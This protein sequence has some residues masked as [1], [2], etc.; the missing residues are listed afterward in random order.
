MLQQSLGRLIEQVAK[1]RGMNKKVII[2]ALEAA[3]LMAAKKKYGLTKEIEAHFNEEIDDIELFQFKTV[4]GKIQDE[5]MEI[6]LKEAKKLDPE[7]TVGD[8]I[9]VKLDAKKFGRIDAQTVKQVITQKVLEA[10]KDLVYKEYFHRKGEIISGIVRRYERGNVMVDLGKTEA[11]IPPREQIPGENFRSGDRVQA[12]ILDVQD[13]T[14]R[15]AQVVLSR[16]TPLYLIK[17]FELEVPEVSE[18]I[19]IIKGAAR[20]P[21]FRSKISVYSKD[22]DVDAVG[23]CVGV[24]GTRV[25]NVVQEL[26]GEKIDIVPWSDNDMQFVVNALAPAEIS[27]VIIDEVNHSM[28]VIV[29]DDQLSLAIG[30]KGQNVRLAMQLAGWKLDIITESKILER[31]TRAKKSLTAIPR[32]NETLAMGLYQNGYDTFE[33]VAKAEVKDLLQVPGIGD[34][35]KA[36]SLKQEAQVLMDQGLTTD[37]LVNP[38]R[39][40][41]Q[42]S[43]SAETQKEEVK[44]EIKEEKKDAA[45][46]N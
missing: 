3:F 6:V 11:I 23:A 15:G 29:P 37:K 32:V 12:Y 26:R 24:K 1:D 35:E 43:A 10:E 27:K 31:T 22:S 13:A 40:E 41:E 46:K 19:V 39:A 17:L 20:E 8:S 38:K 4:V 36:K 18:G 34:E 33:D 28:E 25:Q 7:A 2:E 14:T 21:G 5:E 42:V 16:S 44:E 30:K 9:G 45:E